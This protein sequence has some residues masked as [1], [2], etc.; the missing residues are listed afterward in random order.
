[1]TPFLVA[2]VFLGSAA[3]IFAWSQNKDLN[4]LAGATFMLVMFPTSAV[5]VVTD[6]RE[7]MESM[8][9]V[10]GE[11]LKGVFNR[12][13]YIHMVRTVLALAALYCFVSGMNNLPE[14]M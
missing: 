5:F 8:T 4:F 6:T 2:M 12:W 3:G 10:Y 14:T 9:D 11:K 7:S 1:M 13:F